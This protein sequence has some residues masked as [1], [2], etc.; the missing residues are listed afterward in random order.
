MRKKLGGNDAGGRVKSVHREEAKV[1]QG[2][3]A[4]A[5]ITET[6]DDLYIASNTDEGGVQARGEWERKGKGG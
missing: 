1:G 6:T 4:A 3:A 5:F 2:G